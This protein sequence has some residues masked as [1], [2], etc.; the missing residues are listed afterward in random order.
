MAGWL[1]IAVAPPP[2]GLGW[3]PHVFWRATLQEFWAALKPFQPPTAAERAAAVQEA[4]RKAEKQFQ[5]H[6][7]VK[8]GAV[9]KGMRGGQHDAS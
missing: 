4:F 6:D 7:A 5:K 9:D 1:S 8:S 2:R 3:A